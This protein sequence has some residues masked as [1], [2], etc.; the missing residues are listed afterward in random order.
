MAEERLDENV[1]EILECIENNQNF[2]LS[3]GAGSGKTYAL[4]LS[5]KE[6]S[7]IHPNKRIACIT[8]TNAAADEIKERADIPHLTV[9]TIHE[10]L[11]SIISPYQIELRS[12]LEELVNNYD[13]NGTNKN[14]YI[15]YSSDAET[16]QL[17]KEVNV[18]YKE[19]QHL[20]EG[21]ITHD[22][23]LKIAYYM[24][25]KYEKLRII[26]RD[27][28]SF[29]FVDE[30]QDTSPLVISILLEFVPKQ[31]CH[32][33][34]IGFFGDAM[35][36][37]Y[38][39]GVG[40]IHEYIDEK[41]V[42]E[43]KRVQNRRNPMAIIEL[44]NRIRDDG[45][46]QKPS[47]DRNAPNMV[48]GKIKEG[49]ALF[50]YSNN[51]SLDDVLKSKYCQEWDIEENSTK[52]LLLTRKLI[53][54]EGNFSMLFN[55][56]GSDK[57]QKS[58]KDLK[59]R[60][61]NSKTLA[62]VLSE[63]SEE[64]T[65][66]DDFDQQL[67]EYAKTL[68]IK[69]LLKERFIN[70]STDCLT[71]TSINQDGVIEHNG[72]SSDAIIDQLF[73]IQNLTD[74][75]LNHYFNEFIRLTETRITYNSDKQELNDKMSWLLNAENPTIREVIDFADQS[76]ICLKGDNYNS[77]IR[78]HPYLAFKIGMIP[79]REFKN[80]Y[81]YQE[82]HSPLSTQHRV[83]GLEYKHVLAVLDNG[84]WNA[85]NFKKYLSNDE[86]G[87]STVLER[88]KKLFYV[89]CTRAKDD[90]FA[91]Y[92]Q[93]DTRLLKNVKKLFGEENVINLDEEN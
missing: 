47:S 84:K 37:I 29:I 6:I 30:Y 76:G 41:K 86:S 53:A 91:F 83:K 56:Y 28:Y 93:P 63:M 70:T 82:A 71:G 17:S 81:D 36:S 74:L 87:S 67:F 78:Q 79:Y 72:S 54:H 34:V 18:Q 59:Y 68:P 19:Y 90:F 10:F 66:P 42:K 60:E 21:I 25:E 26:L 43:I 33:N 52:I 92:K 75:Y 50:L 39:N 14:Y 85:Y 80:L 5:L 89:C 3:G 13:P 9:K 55:A 45:I 57:V 16:F 23:V 15:K 64:N 1:L 65:F 40:N 8:Y 24:F 32:K 49:K 69:D 11:W 44:A 61:D 73:R 7:K 48:N 51:K 35:Q 88:T 2:L 46:K 58:I 22:D 4:T 77:F 27:R 62:N 20:K 38:D 12:A 31:K